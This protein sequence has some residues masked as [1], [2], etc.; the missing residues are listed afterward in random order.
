[1]KWSQVWLEY[2]FGNCIRLRCWRVQHYE[3]IRIPIRYRAVIQFNKRTEQL[4]KIKP[5]LSS[6]RPYKPTQTSNK[7]NLNN[8][9]VTTMDQ[10]EISNLDIGIDI[11][12]SKYCGGWYTEGSRICHNRRHFFL[13]TY[14]T[15]SLFDLAASFLLLHVKKE[16]PEF[17]FYLF[18]TTSM[19]VG[20]AC[21]LFRYSAAAIPIETLQV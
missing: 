15:Q 21:Y 13:S 10:V 5:A 7:F 18:R 11:S 12:I 8:H 6:G 19:G 2:R 14:P 17:T 20:R 3:N 4:K 16:R 1:M 9:A